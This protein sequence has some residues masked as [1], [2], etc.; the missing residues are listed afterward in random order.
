MFKNWACVARSSWPPRQRASD[1]VTADVM[2]SQRPASRRS[3]RTRAREGDLIIGSDRSSI[4]TLV[5]RTTS[6]HHAAAS[7][8]DGWLRCHGGGQEWPRSG[9]L[10]A[11]AMKDAIAAKITSL[12]A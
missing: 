9:R 12:P 11:Q 7:A 10:R 4:G 8:A 5:E 3:R 1:H 2:I 6:V